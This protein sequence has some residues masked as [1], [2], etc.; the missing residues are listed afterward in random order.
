MQNHTPFIHL[1]LLVSF[2]GIPELLSAQT[3][4]LPTDQLDS[5]IERAIAP[6]GESDPGVA[7]LVQMGD[8]RIYK[9]T[10][11][12]ANL[13]YN[14]ALTEHA[15]FDIASLAKQFTGLAIAKLELAGQL[16]LDDD[17]RKYLPEVPD[18]GTTIT[19]RHLLYHTSGLRDVGELCRIGNFAGGLTGD[20][21]LDIIVRQKALNFPPGSAHDYSNTGYVL[22]ALIVER[23]TGQSLADWS[24]QHI[25]SPLQMTESRVNDAPDNLIPNRA[26]AYHGRNGNYTFNQDNGMSLIGSSSVFSLLADMG[27]WMAFLAGDD[28]AVKLMMQ[29]GSLADGSSVGYG[30]GHSIGQ[31]AGQPLIDHSGVTPAGFRTLTAY[32]PEMD[33][34]LVILSNWG[35]LEVV[36]ELP[37]PILNLLLGKHPAKEVS[38]E[39]PAVEFTEPIP[40]AM[41]DIYTGIYLFNGEQPVTIAREGAQLSIAVA[42]MSTVTLEP[43]ST[44]TFYLEPM[45]SLLI[46]HVSDEMVSHVSIEENGE[47]GGELRPVVNETYWPAH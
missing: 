40:E 9:K 20:R 16:K 13:E 25:F 45:Q 39:A 41:L 31:F 37:P 29:P 43:R 10:V 47:E 1:F 30:Y 33:A 21:A 14:I 44:N 32:L 12:Q 4:P 22:L 27:K 36:Q 11:G 34:R 23:R 38:A 24:Q 19:L 3:S 28:P 26:V 7:A 46:F 35:E 42:G 18:F 2:L 5:I 17:V 8:G 15:V 6:A